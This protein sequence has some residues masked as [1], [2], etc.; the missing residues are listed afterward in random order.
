MRK[1]KTRQRRKRQTAFVVPEQIDRTE[2]NR[3][4]K[5]TVPLFFRRR[6]DGETVARASLTLPGRE[7]ET[8][9]VFL[10]AGFH[11]SQ[12]PREL[13]GLRLEVCHSLCHLP[14]LLHLRVKTRDRQTETETERKRERERERESEQ[15]SPGSAEESK[16]ET[17]KKEK[18]VEKQKDPEKK[19][20]TTRRGHPGETRRKDREPDGVEKKRTRDQRRMKGTRGGCPEGDREGC[21]YVREREG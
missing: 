20:A 1:T 16:R 14:E 13:S 7:G 18:K 3:K 9:E 6:L 5:K 2:W 12:L 21:V 10:E 19:E 17:K 8:Y 15:R 11:Q 4:E